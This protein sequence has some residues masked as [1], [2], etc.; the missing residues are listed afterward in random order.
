MLT[1]EDLKK[2]SRACGKLIEASEKRI[3]NPGF[4]EFDPVVIGVM[5]S[6]NQVYAIV[7][8]TTFF[9]FQRSSSVE[10]ERV[11]DFEEAARVLQNPENSDSQKHECYIPEIML[12]DERVVGSL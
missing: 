4:F 2:T 9:L 12:D 6:G 5:F 8:R 1:V 11:M 10:Y 7:K 3:R